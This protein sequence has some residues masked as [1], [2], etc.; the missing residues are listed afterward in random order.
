LVQLYFLKKKRIANIDTNTFSKEGTNLILPK[1]T[2]D[3]PKKFSATDI[4]KMLE[5]L[6]DN[7]FAM[8]GGHVFQH[9][10]HSYG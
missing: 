6:I 7:I 2:T 9:S 8:F 4:I 3:S 10:Q 1:K 5:F